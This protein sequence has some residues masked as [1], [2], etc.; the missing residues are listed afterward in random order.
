MKKLVKPGR[1]AFLAVFITT[2]CVV[3][4]VFLYKLQIVEG[5]AY[6]E[7]SQNSIVTTQTVTGARGNIL[8]RYGRVL[9]SNS[10]CNNL[11][12][13]DV[14]LFKQDDP[15]AILLQ[16]A[17]AVEAGG[18]RYTDTLPI[19]NEAPFEYVSN[20]S[21]LQRT[22]LDA[23]IANAR[24]YWDDYDLPENPTAVEL[25]AFFRQ[26]YD[27]GNSYDSEEMRII[28]G[29]R[30]EINIRYIINT[31]DYIFAQD[32]GMDLITRLLENNTPGIEVQ[33][34]YIREFKTSAAAHLLGYVGLM[35]EKEFETYK[36]KNYDLDAYVGKDGA[37]LAFEDYLH[38][39]DGVAQVTSTSTGTLVSKVYTKEPQPGENVYLTIDIGLQE[40]AEQALNSFITQTNAAREEENAK[41]ITYG[42]DTQELITGGAV[43]VVAVDSGEPLCLASWP[44]Y[45]PSTFLDDYTELNED[46]NAPLFNRALMGTYAPGST[47]KPCTAIAILNEGIITPAT[48]LYD[49]GIFMKYADQNYAPKCW[50]YP[51]SHGTI[52][53]TQAITV[54]CNYF[55]YYFGD[56]LGI[57]RMSAYAAAFGLGEK[58]GIELPEALGHMSTQAYK[59]QL[60]GLPWYAGDTVQAAIGQAYSQFTPL[61]LANYIATIANNGNRY[62]CSMLKTVRSYDYSEKIY[63][64]E[65]EVLSTEKVD[66]AYYDAVHEGMWGLTQDKTNDVYYAFADCPVHVACKTGTA[67]VGEDRMNNAVFVCYAPYENPEIAISVVVEKGVKGSAVAQIAREVV[68]YYFSFKNGTAEPEAELTPLK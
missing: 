59:E 53:L 15:N 41:A 51:G 26:R 30:Y 65:P 40:E 6:Y 56:L 63:E 23:Y 35:N 36:V 29:I 21:D 67:Q 9:V 18:D 3:Y 43:T 34:S 49:E 33:T 57:D 55:F 44:G 47:F 39:Q 37:E 50:I 11:I 14:E 66:Q 61:Q 24:K 1:L 5:A 60:E 20:M 64:R 2:L 45:D 62:S 10:I 68:D 58:T 16:L 54:S 4:A 38:G 19:T 22:R 7:Q 25:M 27:I 28:A 31:S 48:T 8:D 32:V 13:D 52:N 12:I 46:T 42:G 17:R